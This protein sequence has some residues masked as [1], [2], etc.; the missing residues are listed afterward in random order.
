MVST[1]CLLGLFLAA[2]AGRTYAALST[3]GVQSFTSSSTGTDGGY[4]YSFYTTGKSVTYINEGSGKYKVTWDGSEDFV[5]GKGW[6][7][8]AER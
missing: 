4:Y 3:R 6:N 2:L 5:A 1:S 8:G 7:P